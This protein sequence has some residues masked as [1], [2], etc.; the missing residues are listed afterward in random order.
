MINANHLAII[1]FDHLDFTQI[2]CL[3]L[4]SFCYNSLGNYKVFGAAYAIAPIKIY[5]RT[6][7]Y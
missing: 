4:L 6:N 7:I 5:T 1:I 3:S 2:M